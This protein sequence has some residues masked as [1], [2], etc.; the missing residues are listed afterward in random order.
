MSFTFMHAPRPRTGLLSKW[1]LEL[2]EEEADEPI[3][4]AQ[5][6]SSP[7][8]IVRPLST[9][10]TTVHPLTLPLAF[11]FAGQAQRA[12]SRIQMGSAQFDPLF[13]LP[14]AQTST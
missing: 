12:A 8:I 2:A 6:L 1:E 11:Y 5:H 13:A 7:E 9:S 3:A 10:S 4:L 14:Q